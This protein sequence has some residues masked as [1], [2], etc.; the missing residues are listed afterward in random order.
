VL[1]RDHLRTRWHQRVAG[2]VAEHLEVSPDERVDRALRGL[3][4]AVVQI[5]QHP[6]LLGKRRAATRVGEARDQG[7]VTETR[8]G[9]IELVNTVQ[10]VL[11]KGW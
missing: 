9:A 7:V 10:N 3:M 11:P 5:E 6:R 2:V 1:R 4:E 8:P